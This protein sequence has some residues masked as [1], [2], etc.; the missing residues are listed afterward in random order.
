MSLPASADVVVVG[1]GVTGAATAAA[2]AARGATVVLLDKED[3]PAR[4]ASG[5]AQGSLRVQ[6][7]HGAE[8]RLAEE[9]LRLWTEAAADGDFEL[10][11]GGN[12]YLLTRPEELAR[13]RAL[14]AEAHRAGLTG[15]ELLDADATRE[16]MP[17]AT[18]PLLGAMCSPGD[19]HCHPRKGTELYARRARA[20]GA[21][22][23]YGVK[24]VRLLAAGA[25]IT[26][27]DTT[28]GSIRAGA[29]VVAA[30]I[31]TPHL[32]RT[33]GLSVP[34]MPV[35]MSELETEPAEPLFAQSIRAFGFGA[36]QRPNGKLIVSA[37]LN[38]RVA[39]GVSLADL[40]G[41]RYWLPRALAFRRN[42]RLSVDLARIAHQVRTRSTLSPEHVPHVSP[43]PPCDRPL[44]D[45]A[46]AR[47]ASVVPALRGVAVSRY[48]G[49]V[50]DMTPD[51][52][53]IIDGG[54]GPS[55]LT[56]VTGLCGHGFTLGPVLG[57]IAADLATEGRTARDIEE[58][59][60]ARFAEGPVPQPEMTI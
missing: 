39:H 31:W 7:R 16:V 57:E 25:R 50:V 28:E 20:A 24:A 30:G 4:E 26:G 1:S 40:H 14:V 32:A 9:A 53:P 37:G 22:P 46:L 48:W 27:V 17:S 58:F 45:S 5:R 43:E 19:A 55:G 11:T 10:V 38:A 44:V 35:V 52:L 41:L 42:L 34:I 23:A 21:H 51:G 8:L 54:A 36:V 33:V 12:L 13:L 56:L 6:G 3:G 18:G 2:V 59:R 47:L 49:G 15:V 29:V 60:L